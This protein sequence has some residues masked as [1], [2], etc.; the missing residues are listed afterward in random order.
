MKKPAE[1]PKTESHF[2]YFRNLY[3][4]R[5]QVRKALQYTDDEKDHVDEF[6]YSENPRVQGMLKKLKE[7][8]LT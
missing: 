6:L 1:A 4:G 3:E 8:N 2:D 7:R 5:A